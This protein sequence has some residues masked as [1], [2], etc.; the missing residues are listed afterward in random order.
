MPA[1]LT[2]HSTAQAASTRRKSEAS[3]IRPSVIA[4]RNRAA[5]R[6]RVDVSD[7]PATRS[8]DEDGPPP[9]KG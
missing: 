4:A 1:F 7:M 3:R 6:D 9:S 8:R 2:R 5:R